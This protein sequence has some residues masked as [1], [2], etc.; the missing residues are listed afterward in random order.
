M[1]ATLEDHRGAQVDA[2]TLQALAEHTVLRLIVRRYNYVR[3][4][5]YATIYV[6]APIIGFRL[7][8]LLALSVMFPAIGPAWCPAAAA[9]A[10]GIAGLLIA[11]KI[12]MTL[13]RRLL[14]PRLA[15]KLRSLGFC[16]SC[17][18]DLRSLTPAPDGCTVCPECG[19]AWRL[20][21]V[22]DPGTSPLT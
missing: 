1:R 8:F 14:V 9:A 13:E 18:Y 15:F 10:G 4:L 17:G 5:M 11:F 3:I 20:P 2:A 19:A 12:I 22:D 6:P 16:A 21:A 7:G